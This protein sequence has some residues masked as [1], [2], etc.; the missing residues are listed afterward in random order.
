MTD[1]IAVFCESSGYEAHQLSHAEQITTGSQADFF[2]GELPTKLVVRSAGSS[3]PRLVWLAF[4]FCLLTSARNYAQVY[5]SG[6]VTVLPFTPLRLTT[7]DL[8]GDGK[9]DLIIQ[10]AT[11]DGTIRILLGNGDGTF[12]TRQTIA[13]PGSS[14]STITVGD[15]NGDGVPDLV[16]LVTGPAIITFLGNGD[17]TF[18]PAL[19]SAAASSQVSQQTSGHIALA[20]FD[21]D[22]FTDLVFSDGYNA[23]FP[24]RGDGHGHFTIEPKLPSYDPGL[25][26]GYGVSDLY[27]FDVNG[28]GRPDLVGGNN[29]GNGSIFNVFLNQ[30]V[31]SFK[32]IGYPQTNYDTNFA[33][34]DLDRDGH[35]DAIYSDLSGKVWVAY[36]HSDGTFAT[37]VQ[38][39]TLP[40]LGAFLNGFGDLHGDGKPRVFGSSPAGIAIAG[41]ATPGGAELYAGAFNSGLFG[42][43]SSSQTVV[44]DF[45][46]DGLLDVAIPADQSLVFLFGK[47]DGTFT[48]APSIY[49]PSFLGVG[50]ITMVDVAGDHIPDAV[51]GL[52]TIFEGNGD[53]TFTPLPKYD[54]FKSDETL[55]PADFD[56]D[57]NVDFLYG[58]LIFFGQ[59]NGTFTSKNFSQPTNQ[60]AFALNGFSALGDFNR[61]GKIDFVNGLESNSIFVNGL[62]FFSSA[63]ASRSF[64]NFYLPMTEVPGPLGAGDFDGDGCDDV[65]VSGQTQ[66]F[67]Y[68][69]D[70][71]G[72][73]TQ[74]GS[75]FTGFIGLPYR[76]PFELTSNAGDLIV[77]DLDGDGHL[78]PVYTI[79]SANLARVL[80][81]RGDG[82]F[83]QGPDISLTFAS[84]FVTAGDLD[85]DG[86]P[87]LVFS[88]RSVVTVLH[89]RPNRT[90]SAPQYL[91]AGFQT[92]KASLADL[93]RRGRLDI[94]IPNLG[95]EGNLT[96]ERGRSFVPFLSPLPA[97]TTN[98]VNVTLNVAPEPSA[99]GQAFTALA[100]L[101]PAAGAATPTGTTTF[102]L[103]GLNPTIVSLSANGT[104]SAT[105]LSSS[106]GTHIVAVAYPGDAA[107]SAAAKSV[108][109]VVTGVAT[110][111]LLSC[112]PATL[113]YGSNV[114]VTASV[115]SSTSIPTGSLALSENGITLMRSTLTQGTI[116]DYTNVRPSIGSHTF[117]AT[118]V[119]TGPYLAST[120][121]CTFVVSSPI[122]P[123]TLTISA[124]P[125]PAFALAPI[126]FLLRLSSAS[127]AALAG[128]IVSMSIGGGSAIFLPVDAT[129]SATYTTTRP[130]GQY[131]VVASFASTSALL[132][133]TASL[134]EIVDANPTITTLASNSATASQNTN[135][136]FAVQVSAITGLA[137]PAGTLTLLDGN[138][139]LATAS[140]SA[141]GSASFSY[142]TLSVGT[143]SLTA[144][145]TPST[146]NFLPSRSATL[147][148]VITPSDF[149]FTSAAP[150]ITI[151]T[152]HHASLELGLQS[153]GAYAG[154]V[155][156]GCTPTLPEFLTCDFASTTISLSANSSVPVRLT[157]DTDAVRNF[158][159]GL[160]SSSDGRLLWV[161]MLP[162]SLA[163]LL[164]TRRRK[165][166]RNFVLCALLA[167]CLNLS[168]CSGK[169]PGHTLPGT[170]NIHL[171][172]TGLS[173]GSNQHATHT[174]DLSVIVTP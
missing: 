23:I 80:Y 117:T 149:V 65:A 172:A 49:A 146:V 98:S 125:N 72:N 83:I 116:P 84:A 16:L 167:L 165:A 56:Q 87:D 109:H 70:C 66:I 37:A 140:T 68:K 170:Y 100:T 123:T 94:V 48:A 147:L 110:T 69:S 12:R 157:L 15:V 24:M 86:R 162:L 174:L 40:G 67:I 76:Y 27:A 85:N 121:A 4:F 21:A 130:T 10:D 95:L 160:S 112:S 128:N 151:Q 136:L 74:T 41:G 11:Q 119:P 26:L 155:H 163:G 104:S 55:Y 148:Q 58:D 25:Y 92:G 118:F 96:N 161:A 29:G 63:A 53:G 138:V 141:A 106:V 6:S 107:F 150:T 171:T 52:S 64:T 97:L 93:R 89:G 120:A 59:G 78:D 35:V 135:V 7:A 103:D 145:F 73:F 152:E 105:F 36:G 51:L 101:S 39:A 57:G 142:A 38:F 81:G 30:G 91:A 79:S 166:L 154:P 159:A 20:D 133:S 131:P 108:T 46:G 44:A 156:L 2:E 17:G 75:Y 62:T 127:P 43:T 33:F 153:L 168:A 1:P 173:Q 50:G 102:T 34:Y 18:Q 71:K 158:K 134:T 88:G 47:A 111:T 82:S 32:P 143:H 99:Y 122:P 129:G 61:D 114:L 19:L 42:G 113:V 132:A 22:G 28:D 164:G 60:A 8:N 144:S 9:P 124:I 126:S 54:Y 90:F 5:P 139:I 31:F 14:G 137:I 169:Y 3:Y 77:T 115:E 13:L 45:N